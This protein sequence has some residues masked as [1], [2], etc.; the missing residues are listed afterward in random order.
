MDT[1]QALGSLGVPGLVAVI[2]TLS[3]V[4]I[5]LYRKLDTVQTRLEA[6]LEQRVADAKETRDKIAEPIEKQAIMSERIYDL[7]L[8]RGK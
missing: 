1:A 4:I 7:L 5:F 2:L 3:G 8:S 6:I